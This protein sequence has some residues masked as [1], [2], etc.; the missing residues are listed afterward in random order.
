LI[1]DGNQQL[2]EP[3]GR[4]REPVRLKVA[5]EETNLPRQGC[6]VLGEGHH[7]P[8]VISEHHVDVGVLIGVRVEAAFGHQVMCRRRL[9]EL[10]CGCVMMLLHLLQMMLLLLGRMVMVE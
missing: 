7:L 1:A 2:A 6:L 3:F 9:M 10:A 5:L 8:E 4:L